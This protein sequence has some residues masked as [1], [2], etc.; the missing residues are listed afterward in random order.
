MAQLYPGYDRCLRSNTSHYGLQTL[1]KEYFCVYSH[2]SGV[3]RHAVLKQVA[4]LCYKVELR[5]FYPL[6]PSCRSVLLL[7]AEPP[8]EE[9]GTLPARKADILTA[10]RLSVDCLANVRSFNIS[11]PYG[12]P[13]PVTTIALLFYIQ[14]MFV[15]HRKHAQLRG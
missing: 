11:Q 13:R 15:P 5:G 12:P 14:M 3:P 9:G 8:A 2:K 7:F 10:V 6:N 1:D 4:A